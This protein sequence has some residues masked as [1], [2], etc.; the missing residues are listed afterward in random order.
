M[1]PVEKAPLRLLIGPHHAIRCKALCRGGNDHGSERRPQ[2]VS[3]QIRFHLSPLRPQAKRPDPAPGPPR[4]P[5][6]TQELAQ[7]DSRGARTPCLFLKLVHH[8]SSCGIELCGRE[9][10]LAEALV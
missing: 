9:P 2:P 1:S 6:L 7:Q 3:T 5:V 4:P 8:A 10:L